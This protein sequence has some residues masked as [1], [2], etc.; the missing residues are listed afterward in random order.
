MQVPDGVLPRLCCVNRDFNALFS[1]RLYRHVRLN[2]RLLQP[3]A[4]VWGAGNQRFLHIK[5]LSFKNTSQFNASAVPGYEPVDGPS[6]GSLPED[7]SALIQRTA[8]GILRHSPA[9]HTLQ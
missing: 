3:N 8:T 1:P 6:Q 4:Q 7:I 2:E 5:I 9:L